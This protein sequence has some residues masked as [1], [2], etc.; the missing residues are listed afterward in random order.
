MN[1]VLIPVKSLAGAKRRLAPDVDEATREQLAL[2]MLEDMIDSAI[3]SRA[4]QRVV[5]VSAD[6]TLLARATAAGA[7]SLHEPVPRGLN[8]AVSWAA[9]LLERAGVQRLL[10]IPGDVPLLEPAEIDLAFATDPRG[11]P[12]VLIPSAA[13]TGTNG[14]LTS[15]PTVLRPR[16][17]GDSLRAHQTAAAERGMTALVLRLPSFELDVDTPADLA[18]LIE[19]GGRTRRS[20]RVG[21]RILTCN[22]R[23]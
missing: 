12:V 5:V 9:A 23:I 6:G 8:A 16:F 3:R 19:R 14:L 17:E 21:E 10:T 15:P 18:V 13:G 2:A 4:A 22:A 11:A 1:A 20:A 7:E